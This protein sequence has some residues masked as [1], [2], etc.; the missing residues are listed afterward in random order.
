MKSNL[1]F[2]RIEFTSEYLCTEAY[3]RIK[4]R[5]SCYW[6]HCLLS[7]QFPTNAWAWPPSFHSFRED[8]CD[9]R[10]PGRDCERSH[11]FIIWAWP[12]VSAYVLSVVAKPVRTLQAG[13]QAHVLR[14]CLNS[15]AQRLGDYLSPG[16]VGNHP[17]STEI[18]SCKRRKCP[19]SRQWCL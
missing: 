10:D 13:L 5:G 9:I 16:R 2:P 8:E 18:H 4:S 6:I 1:N 3:S 12:V 14:P 7:S 19:K 17:E 11:D 15:Y